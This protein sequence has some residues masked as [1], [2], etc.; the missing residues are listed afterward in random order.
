MIAQK[1]F[2]NYLYAQPHL[3]C[4]GCA[5]VCV[6]V[7]N[8]SHTNGCEVVSHCNLYLHPWM[9]NDIG[10]IPNDYW[11]FVYL[12]YGMMSVKSFAYF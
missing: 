8:S 12:L 9:I 4:S 2:S 1:F 10:H 7:L 5:C 11:P 6:C 3:L